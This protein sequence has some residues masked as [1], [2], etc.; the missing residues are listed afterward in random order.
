MGKKLIMTLLTRNEADI[1]EANLCFHLSHGVDFIVV[2][3]NGSTDKTQHI[4]EKYAKKGVLAYRIVSDHT[5]SQAKWVSEMAKIA[6]TEYGAT[7][8]FHCDTDEFWYPKSGSLQTFLPNDDEIFNV[9]LLNYLPESKYIVANPID[10]VD[11]RNTV[12]SHNYFL[13]RYPTKVITSAKYTNIVQGN[14]DI[15]TRHAVVRMNVNH[16]LIHHFP[17]RS[18][19]Q[20]KKKVIQTGSAYLKNRKKTKTMGW[21][22]RSWFSLYK[23]GKLKREYQKLCLTD[24]IL[25]LKG[26][27]IIRSARV[28]LSIRYAEELYTLSAVP[29]ELRLLLA[30]PLSLPSFSF[31]RS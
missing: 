28:P 9:S 31:D 12:G 13:Y 17:I 25:D 8:L 16:V 21:H 15:K 26:A 30:R 5:I 14:H 27:D 20:F 10:Q 18:Y 6:V 24:R 23:K 2:T 4:L 11:A 19:E 22:S 29:N 1:L 7:H 3:D